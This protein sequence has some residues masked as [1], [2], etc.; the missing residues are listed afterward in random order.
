MRAFLYQYS[1]TLVVTVAI[2]SILTPVQY[3]LLV[4]LL[5]NARRVKGCVS[6]VVVCAPLPVPRVC[7]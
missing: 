7:D 3:S 5:G 4:D 6:T 1:S 2:V